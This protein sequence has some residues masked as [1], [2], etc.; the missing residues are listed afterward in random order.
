MVARSLSVKQDPVQKA[1]E[2]GAA[3]EEV[4]DVGITVE[5]V[6]VAMVVAAAA[7]TVVGVVVMVVTKVMMVI[8]ST[9]YVIVN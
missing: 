8:T 4:V 3:M 6:E 9:R 1:V 5:G 7:G 2:E